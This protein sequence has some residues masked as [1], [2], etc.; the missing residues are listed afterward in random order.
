MGIE[1][2]SRVAGLVQL[3][4]SSGAVERE[5]ERIELERFGLWIVQG[6]GG[7]LGRA[8]WFWVRADGC[9]RWWVLLGQMWG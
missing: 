4:R 5:R 6:G 9:D 2:R 3:K 8:Q 7:S 1:Q